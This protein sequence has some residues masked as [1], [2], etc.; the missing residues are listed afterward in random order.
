MVS[1][2]R[3]AILAA[4]PEAD[5]MA[6]IVEYALRRGW[7]CFHAYD[8]RR[9]RE[10]YPDLC[11]VRKCADGTARLVY[12]ECKRVGG[13]VSFAQQTWIDALAAVPG[14]IAIVVRPTDWESIERVL[15]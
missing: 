7:A 1:D 13:R 11:C 5:F 8:S 12:L 15:T 3:A 6:Q 9:S 10:G 2:A 14:V 4:Q